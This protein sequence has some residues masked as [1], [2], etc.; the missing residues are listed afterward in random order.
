MIAQ[1]DP[2][3]F[4]PAQHNDQDLPNNAQRIRTQPQSQIQPTGHYQK[5]YLRQNPANIDCSQKNQLHQSQG[6]PEQRNPATE[7]ADGME[8]IL[9]DSTIP[10]EDWKYYLTPPQTWDYSIMSKSGLCKGVEVVLVTPTSCIPSWV[11][12]ESVDQFRQIR[13]KLK[14]VLNVKREIERFKGKEEP[15]D[16]FF[17]FTFKQAGKKAEDLQKE[18][19]TTC[20]AL[21]EV[22]LY[23]PNGIHRKFLNSLHSFSRTAAS[24]EDARHRIKDRQTQSADRGIVIH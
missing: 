15:D 4:N 21:E 19:Q 5:I 17:T 10:E 16:N 18:L 9:R 1:L 22:C 3:Q 24:N 23:K 14:A 11:E 8:N 6:C 13:S 12:G 7:E 20:D 2:G